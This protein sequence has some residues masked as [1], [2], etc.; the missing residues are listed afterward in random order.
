MQSLASVALRN[1]SLSFGPNL[2]L[3]E[4]TFTVGPHTRAGVVGRNGAGKSTLLRLVAGELSADSGSILRNPP[5][6]R[7]GY[8]AQEHERRAGETVTGYLERR[9]G[10]AEASAGLEAASQ[11]LASGAPGS[12]DFFADALD[13]YERSGAADL[14]HRAKAVLGE[15]GL[16]FD[17][18]NRLTAELSGGQASRV[19]LA[20]ILLSRFDLLLLDEPTNDLDFEGLETLEKFCLGSP[21]GM[22][23]VSHDREFLERTTN[24]VIELDLHHRTATEFGG[25]WGAYQHERQSLAREAEERYKDYVDK[26]DDLKARARMQRDWATTG[27]AKAKN[28]PRDNDKMQSGFRVN[29]TE[30]QASKARATDKALE[31]LD[32]IDKP[33]EGWDLRMEL[34][35]AARSGDVVMHLDGA[36]VE[37]GTFCLGPVS[38]QIGAGER[39]AITGPN[40]SGKSTLLL[41]LLQR[42]ALVGGTS[43]IGPSVVIGELDQLR[44]TYSRDEALID[45]FVAS[46]GIEAAEARSLLAKFDL[47][48]SMVV[49]PA[50]RLSAGERTRAMMAALMATKTN[51]LVLDEPS[52]H[53]DI[54]AI[55]QL[56][57][58]LS[59]YN[60][61]M[62]MVTHDR[63][64]L[65]S[66]RFDRTLRV[67]DGQVTEIDPLPGTTSR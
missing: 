18:N 51:C 66:I 15:M 41:A 16:S 64:M 3:S 14:D 28:N 48:A 37:R 26:R 5:T 54:E 13:A 63:R 44:A 8:L 30:K 62:V 33:W 12:D 34:P 65:E 36:V 53:L 23:I 38:M 57:Q 42:I 49:E 22:L 35:E 60:G 20:S 21:L 46:T 24:A 50:A 43:R 32:R 56:E 27:V 25:G 39:I 55:E 40:G 2:V 1:V 19:A 29:K 6:A 45:V 10:A 61:A 67:E 47:L 4:V 31:R 52:N 11:L 59:A 9:T 17:P 58:A 7:I